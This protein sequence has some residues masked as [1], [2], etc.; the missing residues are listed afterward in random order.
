MMKNFAK[1]LLAALVAVIGFVQTGCAPEPVAKKFSL[2][3]TGYGPGY[4]SVNV[5]VPGPTTVAYVVLDYPDDLMM[6]PV[7]LTAN[8]DAKTTFYSDGPQQLLDY[9]IEENTKYYVYLV[10][11][12]GDNYSQVYTY[13]FET[14][15]FHFDQ[16]ATVVGVAPDGYKMYIQVPESVKKSEHGKPGSRAI[17]YTQGDLMIYNFYKDSSDDIYSL[18]YNGGRYLTEDSLVEYSDA[19]N[20]GEAGADINEDGVVDENDMSILWNPIAPGEPVVFLA[21]EFEWMSEPAEYKKGGA[22]DGKT[23]FVNGFPFPGGW[24]DGYYLPC[25]D[26]NRYWTYYG[27]N[28]DGTDKEE[29]GTEGDVADSTAAP[30]T[31]GAGIINNIDLTSPIDQFWTGAFQRKVFRTRVPAKLDGDFEVKVENLRSVDA[32]LT[33]TPTENVYRYLFTVL[34]DGAYGQMLELLDG[35]TEYLQWAVTSYF[36]MY[37]FGQI[38]VVAE[39]GTLSAPPI[40]F[41]LTDFFFDVPSDTKYH[42]LITGMSGDIGSPQCFKHYTFSTPAKTKT[43]GPHI[44]V[45]PL[46]EE[47]DPYEAVFN[48]KCT[49]V[50]NNRAV[51]CYYGANYKMDWIH[52]VNS[53]SSYTYEYLGQ[54]NEFTAA[55]ISQI[56]SEEG[57]TLKIPTIDGETT[58]LVVVAF[59]DENISN[60]IDKYENPID[61][62]AVEDC[63]TP[64]AKADNWNEW[65]TLLDTDELVDHWTMTATV[66][67]GKEI[68]QKVAIKREFVKG[69]DYPETLPAEV[70]QTYRD[71]T[72]WTDEEVYGYFGKFQDLAVEYTNSRLRNQNR[73][74]IE[75]W[76]DDSNGSLTY[77][78][79]WDLFKHEKISMAD[80]SSMFA[81]FGPKIYLNVNKA[82]DGSDSLAISANNMF[83]SPIAQWSVPFYMAGRRSDQNESNTI[84]QWSDDYGNWVGALTFPVTLAEDHNTITI[85][86]L[87][88]AGVK[89]YPNVVGISEG[90]G[91]TTTY[92]LENPI[93][94]DVVITRGWDEPETP[95]VDPETP[96]ESEGGQDQEVPAT[97]SVRSASKAVSPV[98]NPQFV[99][100]TG[101]SDFSSVKER[102]V[103]DG[104]VVTYEKLQ[105]NFEKFRK[106]Q[107]K[108]MR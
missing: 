105:E 98:G 38:Q 18:L 85:H 61:H 19:L 22:M 46:P 34:D 63:T 43:R 55:E 83:V 96:G 26:G 56:N 4:V 82:K 78:S 52:K 76:F 11:A 27:K 1:L 50:A 35:K 47:S 108:R 7:M 17:R 64:Y 95:E 62:P 53:G 103:M 45:T 84:F 16:L 12:L 32:T 69:V 91:G 25:V 28:P 74:L 86:A 44:V 70:L 107:S 31:R 36:A 57:L 30:V 97:R 79:P 99:T 72:N 81:R 51:R 89:Y 66:V 40:E 29:E 9:P 49:S 71:T 60:G 68:K 87:E 42:V 101:M 100:Y 33:I 92:I 2:Q 67:G 41:N 65:N 13:E 21:G 37:N 73:L 23:Y 102:V 54:T 8:A 14:E 58:R 20:Y 106:A 77:L 59:N 104:E 5:T 6:D 48:V 10:A 24:E 90:Y 39:A 15:E 80:V 88:N 75:G 93:I 94:S 3:F